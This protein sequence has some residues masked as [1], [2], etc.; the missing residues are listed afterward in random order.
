VT[1]DAYDDADRLTQVTDAQ[2]PTA[3]VTKYAYDNEN[4]LTKITDALLPDTQFHYDALGHVTQT[5]FPSGLT[6]DYTYD[7]LGNLKTKT[8]RKRNLTTYN[9]DALDRLSSKVY[10]DSTEVDYAYDLASRLTNVSGT[11]A[12]GTYALTYDNLGRLTQTDSTYSFLPS[13]TWTLQYGYDAASNRSSMTDP[14]SASTTYVYD[15]LNR[16][17]TLTSPAGSFGFTYDALGRRTQMTRPNGV[18]TNYSYDNLSRLLSVLHQVGTSTPLDGATYTYD[19]AGNRLSKTDNRTSTASNYGYDNIYQL[20]SATGGSSEAY[21]YDLVGNRLTSA[22][23]SSYVY[24]NSN[25]LSSQAGVTY[26]YDANGNTKT[27]VD[28]TGTTTYNWDFENRL[29]SVTLPASA[30]TVSFVYDPFGR[31]I[32]KSSSTATS[33]HVYDG[34]DQLQEV[35]SAGITVV[36]RYTMGSGIDQPLGET[37]GSTTSFYQADGLGSVTSLTDSSGAIANT[38]TYDSF[39]NQSA[40]TGTVVN[41]FRYTARELDSE[42]GLM[43]YRARYYDPNTGRFLSEDP[44]SALG[45]LNFYPYVGNGPTGSV[46][47]TGLV[48]WV[49]N[50]TYRK[51]GW[52]FGGD[53]S[54]EMPLVKIRCECVVSGYKMKITV[55]FPI[56]ILYSSDD[57]REHEEGHLQ[58]MKDV[59]NKNEP[60]YS[61]N[62]EKI[63]PNEQACKDDYMRTGRSL[64]SDINH[65]L[66]SDKAQ[67]EHEDWLQTVIQWLFDS[68]TGRKK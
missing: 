14:Q 23:V 44:L 65:S 51:N 18:N 38:Y 32:Q 41:P 5:Q 17:Q 35:D 10:N 34:A 31:R 56:E 52:G 67:K 30:G 1:T 66:L 26:T 9:Y 64:L 58:L 63:Y 29:S 57:V 16:L 39:G 43:Y 59:L 49:Y 53:T 42:T 48:D 68:I 28:S 25:Q 21:T 47:P 24:N 54:V 62:Y 20:T 55:I 2:S 15:T 12:N 60:G 27:K 19:N 50:V 13:K 46:D 6:E 4:N 11:A 61:R 3:G 45:K 40:T 8:D 22:G 33:V 36:A 7:Q 37:C